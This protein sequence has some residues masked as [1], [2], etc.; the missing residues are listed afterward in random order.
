MYVY[1][2]THTYV[3]MYVYIYI[4]TYTYI[5]MYVC[6]YIYIYTYV[7]ICIHIYIYIHAS[8]GGQRGK[9]RPARDARSPGPERQVGRASPLKV[10]ISEGLGPFSHI[11]LLKTGRSPPVPPSSCPPK[12]TPP[13]PPQLGRGDDTLGNPHRAQISQLEH[14]ELILLLK[15]NKQFSIE[16]F[17][18]TASQSKV[19]SPPL[20]STP[21]PDLASTV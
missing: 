8:S 2:Y 1:I 6:T 15:V 4:H 9:G 14:F 13:W 18:P 17:E 3:C 5:H 19:S 12:A 10:R 7:Y 20:T 11:E 21:T 16:R